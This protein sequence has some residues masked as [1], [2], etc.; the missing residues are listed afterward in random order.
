MATGDDSFTTRGEEVVKFDR[1]PVP[2]GDWGL[3]LLGEQ[4][5]ISSPSDK[6]DDGT[7]YIAV[8]FQALGSATET[9]QGKDKYV[10]HNLHLKFDKSPKGHQMWKSENQVLALAKALGVE[11]AAKV[12]NYTAKSGKEFRIINPQE[13]IAWLKSFDSRVVN[14]R[15]KIKKGDKEYPDDRSEIVTFFEAEPTKGSAPVDND[16]LFK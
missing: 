4:A 9:S 15:I 12:V 5:E 7:P 2:A 13:V 16:N 14:G 6:N 8:R 10:F 3:K 1:T 11:F